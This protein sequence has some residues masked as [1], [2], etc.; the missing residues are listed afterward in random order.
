M[1]VAGRP[2][3]YVLELPG[4]FAAALADLD[5]AEA[6]RSARVAILTLGGSDIAAGLQ[7]KTANGAKL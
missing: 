5:P 2:E 3:R 7:N 6:K 4:G 1:D